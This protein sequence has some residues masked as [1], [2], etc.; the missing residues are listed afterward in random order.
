M[1]WM[2]GG[3][4]AG[5]GPHTAGWTTPGKTMQ[6]QMDSVDL[7]TESIPDRDFSAQNGLHQNTWTGK[8]GK[9]EDSS[10]LGPKVRR[11]LGGEAPGEEET[12]SMGGLV[13]QLVDDAIYKELQRDSVPF[14]V[15]ACD[16]LEKLANGGLQDNYDHIF[17]HVTACGSYDHLCYS[18][19]DNAHLSVHQPP[20]PGVVP[21]TNLT[22]CGNLRVKGVTLLRPLRLGERGA[23]Y[24]EFLHQYAGKIA[25]TISAIRR[26]APVATAENSESSSHW[27]WTAFPDHRGVLGGFNFFLCPDGKTR[28]SMDA[29]KDPNKE[30]GEYLRT[31]TTS[32]GGVFISVDVAESVLEKPYG[33]SA[34]VRDRWG[35]LG[36]PTGRRD[37]LQVLRS[38]DFRI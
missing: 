21:G 4:R 30:C 6:L 12:S 11:E 9:R 35:K 16:A 20:I 27:R 38:G 15:R 14:S 1:E 33:V 3:E 7:L 34:K 36:S 13:L 37:S 31:N 8:H 32:D 22:N 28:F 24:H 18:F 2:T 19:Y 5:E 26:P 23:F 25:K 29:R 10:R 17:F